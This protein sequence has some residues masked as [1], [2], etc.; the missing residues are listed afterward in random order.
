MVLGDY[1]MNKEKIKGVIAIAGFFMLMMTAVSV[2]ADGDDEPGLIDRDDFT[3][4]DDDSGYIYTTSIDEP[5]LISPNPDGDVDFENLILSPDDD[6]GEEKDTLEIFNSNFF[7][8]LG[9]S[10]FAGL[11]FGLVIFSKKE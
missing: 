8:V 11:V 3:G 6:I 10:G 4:I 2:S 1:K 7:I 9:L 5:Y